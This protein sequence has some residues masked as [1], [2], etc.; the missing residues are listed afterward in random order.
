MPELKADDVLQK[1][2]NS[3]SNVTVIK[4]V[5]IK[6][7]TGID[8]VNGI[9]YADRLTGE[10]HH[11]ELQGVFVQIGLTPNTHWLDK[12]I[13][14]NSRGEIIVDSHGATDIPGVFASG[15]CTN[16]PYKQIIISMGSG[17]TAALSAFDYLIRS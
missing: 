16:S 9:T 1:R 7:I 13:T 15:D 10:K 5:E 8:K 14:R 11:I 3:L 17:A 4:N 2:L 6:E 12:T